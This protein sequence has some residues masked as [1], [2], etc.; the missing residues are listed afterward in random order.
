[1][2]TDSFLVPAA[3]ER[4]PSH[5]GRAPPSVSCGGGEKEP[6]RSCSGRACPSL[7]PLPSARE[8][9]ASQLGTPPRELMSKLKPRLV[10]NKHP[11]ESLP[12]S[13][14]AAVVCPSDKLSFLLPLVDS[15]YS[16]FLSS[17]NLHGWTSLRRLASLQNLNLN[18]LPLPSSQPT[19]S[20]C[21]CPAPQLLQSLVCPGSQSQLSSLVILV[22]IRF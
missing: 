16:P 14:L 17:I 1:M 3:R 8:E 21:R 7:E 18:P 11:S 22:R 6:R 15:V 20:S 19:L 4:D 2:G 12:A 10:T 13:C 9:G 5:L